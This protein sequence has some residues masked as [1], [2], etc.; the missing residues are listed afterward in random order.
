MF[1][2]SSMA[3]EKEIDMESCQRRSDGR[4]E[5]WACVTLSGIVVYALNA[6]KLLCSRVFVRDQKSILFWF[7]IVGVGF[8]TDFALYAGTVFRVQN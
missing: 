4:R 7:N 6:S 3:P 5:C 8:L 1:L 2:V